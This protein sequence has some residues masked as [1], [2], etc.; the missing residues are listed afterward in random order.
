MEWVE[1]EWADTGDLGPDRPDYMAIHGEKHVARVY[2]DETPA[3]AACGVVSYGGMR[4][5]TVAR[6]RAVAKLS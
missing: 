3:G 2:I 6:Q 5:P 4:S 1:L